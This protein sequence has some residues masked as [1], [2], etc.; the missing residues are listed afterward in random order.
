LAKTANVNHKAL[1]GLIQE[2][3]TDLT[4]ADIDNI[5]HSISVEIL[6]LDPVVNRSSK[7]VLARH[8]FSFNEYMAE[9]VNAISPGYNF[10]PSEMDSF[11]PPTAFTLK[12]SLSFTTL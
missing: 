11:L 7:D 5:L 6:K 9:L 8:I 2:H 1:V 4:L 10:L 12:A 3:Y